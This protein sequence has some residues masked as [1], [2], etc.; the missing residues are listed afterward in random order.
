[1]E[2]SQYADLTYSKNRGLNNYSSCLI[3]PT[4]K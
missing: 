4:E 3:Q 1:M 2:L